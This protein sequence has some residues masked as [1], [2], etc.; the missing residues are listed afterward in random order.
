MVDTATPSRQAW[1]ERL[2]AWA[3]RRFGV[4]RDE[5]RLHHRRLFI[6]PTRHGYGYAV[7]LL[8]ML[9][10]AMLLL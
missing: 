7:L 10:A 1:R 8:L 6:L 2:I 5:I 3:T 4:A 9:L